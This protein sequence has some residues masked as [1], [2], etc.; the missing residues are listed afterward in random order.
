ME[1]TFMEFSNKDFEWGKSDCCQFAGDYIARCT[2]SD[3]R[4]RYGEYE[5]EMGAAR[6]QATHGTFEK[7][8]DGKF[9]VIETGYVQRGD[10]ALLDT[11]NGKALGIMSTVGVWAMVEGV[12]LTLVAHKVLKGWRL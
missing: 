1:E 5:S 2:E 9:E 6:A 12:G 10:I 8:L 3:L 11:P 7:L 4:T